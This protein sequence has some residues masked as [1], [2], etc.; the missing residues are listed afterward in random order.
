MLCVGRDQEIRADVHTRTRTSL[1]RDNGQPI[2]EV[3]QDLLALLSGLSGDA[4]TNLGG[5]RQ[6]AAVVADLRQTA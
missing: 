6:D 3:I 4:V 2:E 5:W 1:E